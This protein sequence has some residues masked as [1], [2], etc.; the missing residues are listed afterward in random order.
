[1]NPFLTRV[2]GH[3]N[4]PSFREL[5]GIAHEVDDDL[6]EGI[7]VG[8]DD[9]NA[10][11]PLQLQ[12]DPLALSHRPRTLEQLYGQLRDVN[13]S[14]VNREIL[15]FDLRQIEQIVDQLQ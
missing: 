14:P 12:L 6:L 13:P 3:D 2:A 7:R 4:P 9:R 1:V 8:V 10:L 15:A 11:E 5:E